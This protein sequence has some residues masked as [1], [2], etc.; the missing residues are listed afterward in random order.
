[1]M[2]GTKGTLFF[3]L[4]LSG[5]LLL[6]PI[7][8]IK[9]R[10]ACNRRRSKRIRKPVLTDKVYVEVHEWAGYPVSREKRLKN[11]KVF[12][13]GLEYQLKRFDIARQY[14][15][16]QIDLTV[17]VSGLNDYPYDINYLKDK[18]NRVLNVSNI[19]LDFSGYSSFFNHIKDM[20]NSYVI[21]SNSSV[22]SSIDIFLDDYIEYMESNPD[23]GMLGVSYCTKMYQTL[24]RNNFTPHLQSF[25][26]LTTID[27]LEEVINA[28]HGYFPGVN[29]KNKQL[30]IRNGEIKIS[31]LIMKLGYNLAV[32]RPDNGKPFK[33][34]ERALWNIPQGDIRQKID[35]PNKINR[36]KF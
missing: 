28:N 4:I 19:G 15:R 34:L 30:L 7:L 33:F 12:Q 5:E 11:G 25:F 22:N 26:L 3:Y 27:V 23:V 32:V 2:F 36:I 17:T 9:N 10:L 1:M 21:L 14:S 18:C 6:L 20:P 13:C 24:V 31:Q 35:E 16:H 29:I 8:Y